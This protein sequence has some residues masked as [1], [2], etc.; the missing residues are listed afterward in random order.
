MSAQSSKA[1][2]L[3]QAMCWEKMCWEKMSEISGNISL[4]T[5]P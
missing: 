1:D 2:A 3:G 4:L 5:F